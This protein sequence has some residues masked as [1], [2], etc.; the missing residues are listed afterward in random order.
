MSEKVC[1]YC[2]RP[3]LEG[4]ESISISKND[5][6]KSVTMHSKCFDG[7]SRRLIKDLSKKERK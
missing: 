3:I 1:S 7:A 6:G 4:Q 5:S 2:K